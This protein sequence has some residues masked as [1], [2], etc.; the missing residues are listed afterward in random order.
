MGAEVISFIIPAFDEADRIG[1][2]LE[3]LAEQIDT[4]ACEVVVADN[5]SRDATVSVVESWSDRMPV[6]VLDASARRGPAAARNDAVRAAR[7]D[8]LVFVDADDVV[9]PGYVDAWR[10]LSADVDFATGPVCFFPDGAAPPRDP[11]R[12]PKV[13]PVQMGFRP[14]ALGAN[15]GV[16]REVFDRMGGFDETYP[17]AEDVE[18]SWRLQRE[19]VELQLVPDAVVAKREVAGFVATVR[20][21]FRYGRRD[22]FLYRDFGAEGVPR[23][24]WAAVGRSY[25]GLVARLPFLWRREVRRR[26]AHQLGRRA[27]RLAGSFAAGVVY[28]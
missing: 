3:A 13:L 11:A 15:F 17:P 8:L 24:D 28:P 19:G 16:R 1:A 22:P 7:G 21:Y 6:R 27:G 20:Q 23:P 26:F 18:L 12:A 9:M 5:G 10:G 4:A 25:V 14:Y 2:Q